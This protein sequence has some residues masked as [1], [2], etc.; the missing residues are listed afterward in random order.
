MPVSIFKIE[1]VE[2]QEKLCKSF[3]ISIIILLPSQ[4][5]SIFYIY[6][7]LFL[8]ILSLYFFFLYA[9]INFYFL[10]LHEINYSFFF[11]INSFLGGGEFKFLR[12]FNPY[13]VNSV[14]HFR[15]REL[16]SAVENFLIQ[17]RM[18]NQVCYVIYV[19]LFPFIMTEI[20]IFSKNIIFLSHEI[21]T[22]SNMI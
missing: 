21:F 19:T 9:F 22:L 13:I 11:Y 15:S 1:I 16:E 5:S 2:N 12:G 7:T 6:F 10:I 14:H 8:I 3:V 18:R 20:F 4:Q 17:E